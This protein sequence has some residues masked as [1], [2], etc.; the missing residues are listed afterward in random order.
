MVVARRRRAHILGDE[1]HVPGLVRCLS[2][3]GYR[4]A[5][6]ALISLVTL[7]ALSACRAGRA[8]IPLGPCRAGVALVTLGAGGALRAFRALDALLT[9]HA[10]YALL[11]L[12]SSRAGV[13]L[14]PLGALDTLLALRAGVSLGAYRTGCASISLFALRALD[15]LYTL[16]AL[17]TLR[18]G[19]TLHTLL[20]PRPLRAF[21]PAQWANGHP[22]GLLLRP[23]VAVPVCPHIVHTVVSRRERIFQRGQRSIGVLNVQARTIPAI[24]AGLSLCAPR[25]LCARLALGT[26]YTGDPLRTLLTLHT[27]CA[28]VPFEPLLTPLTL[29]A[30]ISLGAAHTLYTLRAG[31]PLGAGNTLRTLYTLHALN[32]L[33]PSDAARRRRSRWRILH[34]PR[35]DP[36]VIHVGHQHRPTVAL[37]ALRTLYALLSAR[38]RRAGITLHAMHNGIRAVVRH[39]TVGKLHPAA[40]RQLRAVLVIDQMS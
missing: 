17:L 5:G 22:P 14:V 6:V 35:Q 37:V 8:G 31:V 25:A 11:A 16:R 28:G 29:R 2:V 24:R 36:F 26:L 7:V 1:R 15:T 10:L 40:L 19:R 32:A 12:F 13:A 21:R 9:L 34:A 38:P 3:D 39:L 27:L 30:G 23:D 33:R 4:C 18:T 20:S